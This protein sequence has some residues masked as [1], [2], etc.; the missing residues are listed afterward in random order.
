MYRRP[1]SLEII[2]DIRTAMSG[3]AGFDVST[4]VEMIRTGDA[5]SDKTRTVTRE[6]GAHCED[7]HA[8]RVPETSKIELSDQ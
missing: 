5:P 6:E 2:L 7:A 8:E 1:K 4:F 3:E